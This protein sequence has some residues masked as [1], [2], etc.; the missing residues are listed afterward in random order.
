MLKRSSNR[1]SWEPLTSQ[2]SLIN[3]F[4]SSG[5]AGGVPSGGGHKHFR[6][7]PS[8][9]LPAGCH[10]VIPNFSSAQVANLLAHSGS[11]RP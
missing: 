11:K 6:L 5:G 10:A 2:S 7:L 1:E 9:S 4:F 3:G 8:G